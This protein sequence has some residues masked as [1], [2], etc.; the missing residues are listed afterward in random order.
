[1]RGQLGNKGV[2]GG[3]DGATGAGAALAGGQLGRLDHE[4][5]GRAEVARV[6]DEKGVV[7]A[8]FEGENFFGC[9]GEFLG[10]PET[11]AR[12]AGEEEAIEA[13]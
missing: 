13:G 8:E 4:V 12:G 2:A 6:P 11:G 7:A 9:A 3:D 10:E 5:R 1:M